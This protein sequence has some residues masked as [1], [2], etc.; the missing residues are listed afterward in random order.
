[1]FPYA[2]YEFYTCKANGTASVDQFNANVNEASF[3]LQR[4]TLGKSDLE[5]PEALQFATC[6]IV[7]MYI[8]EKAKETSG[9]GK[10]KSETTDGYS[11]SYAIETKDGELLDELLDRKALNIARK[12]LTTT[13]L[14]NRRVGCG[15]AHEC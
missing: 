12:Y 2:N 3:F 1:M 14:L 4:L 5:Q 11:V 10:K 6:A 7:D 15:H 9:N 8:E 13:G